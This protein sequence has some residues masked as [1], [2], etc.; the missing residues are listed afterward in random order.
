[1][2]TNENIKTVHEL[3]WQTSDLALKELL[4]TDDHE[5]VGTLAALHAAIMNA[6]K[7][8]QVLYFEDY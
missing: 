3:L 2:T 6:L 8:S 1:M 4:A 5:R 7:V